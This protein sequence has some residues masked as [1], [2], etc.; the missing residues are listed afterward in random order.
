[1]TVQLE[2]K[3]PQEA[4]NLLNKLIESK[5]SGGSIPA[6]LLTSLPSP[7]IVVTW[8]QIFIT[9]FLTLIVGFLMDI[10]AAIGESRNSCF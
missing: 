4:I 8:R 3:D 10:V 1:M 9:I 6:V 5:E 7:G 2:I